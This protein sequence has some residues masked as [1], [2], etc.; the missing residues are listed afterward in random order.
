MKRVQRFDLASGEFRE[1]RT[2]PQGFGLA[3]TANLTRT[4]VFH[5][6]QPD[7]TV[8]RELRP[9]EEVFHPE[10]LKTLKGATIT[11]DHPAKVDPSN[12]KRETIGHVASTPHRAGKFVQGEIHIHHD[13][14]IDK[15][16]RGKLRELSCGYD[17]DL[18]PTPGE[19]E[20]EPY[21]A[22][23]RNIRYN[24][25]AAGPVGWGR[26]GP[27]VKMHLDKRGRISTMER[28]THY[29]GGVFDPGSPETGGFAL[30]LDGDDH[31]FDGEDGPG[32]V[33]GAAD[34][35]AAM[36]ARQR[37]QWKPGNRRRD[38][39]RPGAVQNPESAPFAGSSRST[40]GAG[41]AAIN[42]SSYAP[43]ELDEE[44]GEGALEG[45]SLGTGYGGFGAMEGMASD[46]D[47]GAGDVQ[48]AAATM[49][50][51]AKAAWLPQN[52]KKDAWLQPRR[53]P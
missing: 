8:R 34:S 42:A 44:H 49:V 46:D 45:A 18:D 15:A 14:A 36:V 28:T 41:Q 53:R 17:C 9:P 12:W 1:R 40:H 30:R 10:S 31:E 22:V 20:G 43:R 47:Q 32:E 29:V 51:R 48:D 4:G 50:A 23:Q 3:V 27:D 7:G 19:W 11:D 5:Y 25:V 38:L 26:A 52:R 13:V 37:D 39:A 2:G 33:M 35:Q 21:D 6:R 16:E 24:H